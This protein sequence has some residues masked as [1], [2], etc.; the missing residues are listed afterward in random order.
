MAT[1]VPFN[2]QPTYPFQFYPVL[3][4]TTYVATVLWSLYGQRY[5]LYIKTVDG[6]TKLSVPLIGSPD[7]G[8][9]E[10]S[11]EET[12]Q[13]I[14]YAD[15]YQGQTSFSYSG[16]NA[17]NLIAG[18]V[19]EGDGIP[20]NTKFVSFSGGNLQVA[21]MYTAYPNNVFIHGNVIGGSALAT[22]YTWTLYSVWIDY[23]TNFSTGKTIQGTYI[24][25]GTV[26]TATDPYD[27]FGYRL[28]LSKPLVG[29]TSDQTN[30]PISI[31]TPVIGN[32]GDSISG[33]H[34]QSGT[35][36]TALASYSGG[37]NATISK[38]LTDMSVNALNVNVQ[39]GSGSSF[40]ILMSQAPTSTVVNNELTFT[41]IQKTDLW[42]PSDDPAAKNINLTAGYFDTPI[43]FR[44]S[45]N[46][47]EIG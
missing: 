19:I 38:P 43:V 24:Q 47:F 13:T 7:A 41:Y 11:V 9:I 18:S 1:I 36:I 22:M 16:D 32:V 27:V 28:Y 15:T 26:I 39:I 23:D 46:N 29:L 2:P 45:S 34:I 20:Y 42:V 17:A 12:S 33:L 40:Q 30:I 5:Y 8:Y 31:V 21:D 10:R 25:A 4:G 3:D 6:N 37:T 14:I 44:T 35:T